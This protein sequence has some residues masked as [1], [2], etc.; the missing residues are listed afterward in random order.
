MQIWRKE[1]AIGQQ[2]DIPGERCQ[3][4]PTTTPPV[5]QQ[6]GQKHTKTAAAIG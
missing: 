5:S 3:R 6:T 4:D 2:Q 1:E